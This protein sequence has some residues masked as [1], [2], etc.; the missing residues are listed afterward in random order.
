MPAL[1][2]DRADGA[3]GR[4]AR[5]ARADQAARDEPGRVH[6]ACAACSPRRRMPPLA[7]GFTAI[8]CIALGAG[9]CGALNQWYEADIDAQD[10]AHRQPAAARRADGPPDRAPFRGRA[11]GLFGAADGGC[12]QLAGG[13]AAGRLDPV[14]RPRLHHLAEAADAAEH[15]H[16]RRRGRLPAADRLGRGDRRDGAAAV[17]AV[18]DHLPVDAAAFLGAVAVRPL[19]LRQ[20]R[21]A[22]A[23]GGRRGRDARAARSSSTACRWPRRRSR[24]GRSA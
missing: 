2:L 24:P 14:L 20:C 7:L 4:L 16:R 21:D 22:D 6:R 12:D 18:R 15:R 17:A 9:A 23:A 3:S 1:E 19:R 13:R 11:G 5:P 10:A 8:L